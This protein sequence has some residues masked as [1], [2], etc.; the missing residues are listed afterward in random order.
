MKASIP[1]ATD[2]TSHLTTSIEEAPVTRPP[3]GASWLKSG[4]VPVLTL[5]VSLGVAT[6]FM[7]AGHPTYVSRA[8]LWKPERVHL[9]GIGL[10]PEGMQD[11]GNLLAT[12]EGL[13]SSGLMRQRTI[14]HLLTRNKAFLGWEASQSPVRL[15]VT[16]IPH[17]SILVAEASS[18]NPEY[19]Q[20]YLDAL[21]SEIIAFRREVHDAISGDALASITA[22][23]QRVESELRAE[24]VAMTLF[25]RTNSTVIRQAQSAA[26][27]EHL[28]RLLTQLSD[29]KLEDLLL[30]GGGAS[31]DDTPARKSI[32]LKMNYVT[33]SME[34]SESRLSDASMVMAENDR[35]KMNVQRTQACYDRLIQL[36]QDIEVVR[37]IDQENLAILDRA[38]PVIRNYRHEIRLLAGS[39][40]GGLGAGLILVALPKFYRGKRPNLNATPGPAS[41]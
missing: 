10:W 38:S 16:Q 27:V 8:T 4:W 35:L 25:A 13:L 32:R 28:A 20:A 9:Q 2:S 31:E 7:Y 14:E 26:V 30:S 5:L 41:P 17:S 23:M 33:K 6:V 3:T 21:M 12:E 24:Q 39:G 19:P 36:I 40:F 37:G 22:R 11:H 29:L 18:S 1:S 34:E 15:R